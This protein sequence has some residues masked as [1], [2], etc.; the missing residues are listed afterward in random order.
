MSST[1]TVPSSLYQGLL[2][3]LV[4]VLELAQRPEGTVTPKAKQELLQAVSSFKCSATF[5]LTI[6]RRMHSKTRWHERKS[7]L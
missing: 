7:S 1:S 3:Q 5:V 4:T 6:L 2:V